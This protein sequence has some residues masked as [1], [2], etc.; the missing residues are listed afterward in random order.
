LSCS[1]FPFFKLSLQEMR[2]CLAVIFLIIFSFQVLPMKVLGKLLAKGQT[3]EEVK[4]DSDCDSDSDGLDGKV[5]K[6]NE[7]IFEIPQDCS[8]VFLV[9]KIVNTIVHKSD[10]LPVCYVAEILSPP[11]NC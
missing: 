6:Y 11:P 8:V 4:G 1:G 9:K 3:E 7:F 10:D 2:K 5:S